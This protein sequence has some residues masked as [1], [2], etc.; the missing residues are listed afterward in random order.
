MRMIKTFN[1][2]DFLS[3]KSAISSDSLLQ[4]RPLLKAGVPDSKIVYFPKNPTSL[5]SYDFS[6]HYGKGF[7]DVTSAVQQTI[8]ILL[9][10]S[11]LANSTI[12]YYCSSGFRN[13]SEYLVLYRSHLSRDIKLQDLDLK[14]IKNYISHLKKQPK[15]Q[16]ASEVIYTQTKAILVKLQSFGW[17]ER[18]DYPKKTFRIP[19]RYVDT[20]KAFSKTERKHLS[21]ALISDLKDILKKKEELTGYELMVCILAIAL[22]CG[23]NTTP[24]LEMTI[25]S[26]KEHP[27]KKN[28][29]LLILYKRR[30]NA[31]HVHSIRQPMK[32]QSTHSVV[33][34]A[35][36]IITHVTKLNSSLRK[37]AK[38]D[39]LFL[40]RDKG[41]SNG[42]VTALS[43]TR[44]CVY[45]Q[46]WVKLHDLKND[47]GEPL[48]VNIS[49]LRKT[50][51]NRIWELSGGD[52]FITAKL[53]HHSV[54]VSQA[55]YLEPPIESE[56]DF[57]YMGKVRV[58]ELL[59]ESTSNEHNT[60]VS[61]CSLTPNRDNK[62]GTT[63][64]CTDFLSCVRCRHMV[65]TKDD[66]YR[67]LSF[68]WL[69]VR[70]REI[71][72]SKR[73]KKY[74]AHIIRIIEKD[75]T[76]QF[77]SEYVQKIKSKAQLTPHP[78]WNL[79]ANLGTDA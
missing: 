55:H 43:S 31:N 4:Y 30:S 52:P 58:Q 67:L 66:L 59:D 41:R 28:R 50:F 18:F 19:S 16:I 27:L 17:L 57:H 13:L 45:I 22:R 24:L 35:E 1:T 33:A 6:I 3:S 26:I 75:I 68:Y 23:V 54:R 47:D 56:R 44:L 25:D 14:L 38:S 74:Y 29:R 39:L 40:Y 49:R 77:D 53:A 12:A 34:D 60:P 73:W 2:A 8:E 21:Q 65:V 63:V 79:R 48:Q 70:E 7:D 51:E 15:A 69:I 64:Y 71:I 5:R 20:R 9:K 62:R 36:V 46:K 42:K 37:E 78:A 76:S 32:V 11:T 61:K 10:N 72:G